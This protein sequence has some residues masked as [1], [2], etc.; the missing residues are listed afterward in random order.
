MVQFLDKIGQFWPWKH[1]F[2]IFMKNLCSVFKNMWKNDV[3]WLPRPFDKGFGHLNP[4]LVYFWPKLGDLDLTKPK[5][6]I[7]MKI[8]TQCLKTCGK[9][10]FFGSLGLLIRFWPFGTK[11]GPF[12]GKIGWFRLYKAKILNFYEKSVLRT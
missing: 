11:F 4:N 8:C 12:W 9:V 1:K 10:T 3:F 6:Q 2:Q 5:F 7:F